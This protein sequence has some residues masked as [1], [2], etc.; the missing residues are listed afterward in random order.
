MD[1]Q[2]RRESVHRRDSIPVSSSS[3]IP[4][5]AVPPPYRRES[6]QPASS[7]TP[8]DVQS[9]R[10]E[11]IQPGSPL[12]AAEAPSHRRESL[13]PSSPNTS[14]AP[15][16]T[17]VVQSGIGSSPQHHQTEKGS[18][19]DEDDGFSVT[20]SYVPDSNASESNLTTFDQ[21]SNASELSVLLDRP[22]HVISLHARGSVSGAGQ[23]SLRSAESAVGQQGKGGNNHEDLS[24]HG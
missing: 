14:P 9:H 8:A 21:A 5:A 17:P 24:P 6:I 3:A 16:P 2:Q 19:D 10:R 7:N 18:D 11:S 23:P 15:P 22:Q 13:L 4:T 20:D 1:P 12:T